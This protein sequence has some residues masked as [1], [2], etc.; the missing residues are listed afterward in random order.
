MR[1]AGMIWLW[2]CAGVAAGASGHAIGNHD[3]HAVFYGVAFGVFIAM[4]AMAM[5]DALADAVSKP[6]KPPPFSEGPVRKGGTKP[7]PATDKPDIR[8]HGQRDKGNGRTPQ[9][10]RDK[11]PHGTAERVAPADNGVMPRCHPERYWPK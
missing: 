7:Q 2:F 4:F 9:D 3:E 5:F 1:K 10:G 11:P 6:R 8:P